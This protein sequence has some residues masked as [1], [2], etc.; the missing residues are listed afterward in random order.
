[1]NKYITADEYLEYKGINLNIEIF[2]DDNASNKVE[3]FVRDITDWC[4]DYLRLVY[5]CNE[6]NDFDNLAN[7]RKVYFKKGVMDQIAYILSN[8]NISLNSGIDP[9]TG[10]ITDYSNIF[11]GPNARQDFRLGAFMNILTE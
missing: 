4:S 1:M 10:A 11:M 2:D 3:R 5:Y 7:F 6:I 9:N 8:G